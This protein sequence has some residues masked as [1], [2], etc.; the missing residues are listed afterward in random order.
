MTGDTTD[1]GPPKA[2]MRAAEWT[3]TPPMSPGRTSIPPVWTPNADLDS[4]ASYSFTDCRRAPQRAYRTG[5]CREE[6]IPCGV[7]L[8]PAIAVELGAD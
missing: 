5:E 6:A 3:A 7:H 8:V 1:D 4:E 2:M